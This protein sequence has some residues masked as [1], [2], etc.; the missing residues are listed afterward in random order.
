MICFK[1]C[2]LH[3]TSPMVIFGTAESPMV[4]HRPAFRTPTNPPWQNRRSDRPPLPT[5][6]S[7]GD[8]DA[9]FSGWH[10]EKKT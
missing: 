1:I 3:Q 10:V 5:S 8:G 9:E 4:N 2:H 6:P 7:P